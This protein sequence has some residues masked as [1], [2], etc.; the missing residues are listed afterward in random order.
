M[1]RYIKF[2]V[3]AAILVAAGYSSCK[4]KDKDPEIKASVTSLNFIAAGET[5]TFDLTSNVEWTISGHAAASWLSVAP[6]SG[7][8]NVKVSVTAEANTATSPRNAELTIAVKGKSEKVT[9]TQ[10][11]ATETPT[12]APNPTLPKDLSI[13][14]L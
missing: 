14:N 3:V 12:V 4:K 1:R 6:P 8:G 7:S 9:I 13:E 2:F 10:E 11:A 5:K